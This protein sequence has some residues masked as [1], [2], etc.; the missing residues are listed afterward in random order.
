MIARELND[1]VCA[2]ELDARRTAAEV[3]LASAEQELA[4]ARDAAEARRVVDAV[5]WEEG[6]G[7][8][9][10]EVDAALG[11]IADEADAAQRAEARAREL[12]RSLR[13]KRAEILGRSSADAARLRVEMAN[14]D[15]RR[16]RLTER[17]GAGGP[18]DWA[19][20]AAEAGRV[21]AGWQSATAAVEAE[22][23][24]ERAAAAARAM[25]SRPSSSSSSTWSSGSSSTWSSSSSSSS[26][27]SSS[28][29]G[30]S[31]SSGGGSGGSS[32]SSGGRS[33]GSKW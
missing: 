12:L 4:A 31:F 23:A 25:A 15:T 6:I 30:S 7:P 9:L 32:Y 13:D 17:V 19:A 20:V 22:E 24:A 29:G 5:R 2:P 1:H 16:T 18:Q 3:R 28:S 33:G 26:S 14:A 27:W 10:R 21:I 11:A 8:V